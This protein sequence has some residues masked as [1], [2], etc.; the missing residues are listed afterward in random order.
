MARIRPCHI[1]RL[2]PTFFAAAG[3]SAST[4]WTVDRQNDLAVFQQINAR[5]SV[6]TG[7]VSS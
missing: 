1:L 6:S 5:N 3:I 4:I 7:F 2:T